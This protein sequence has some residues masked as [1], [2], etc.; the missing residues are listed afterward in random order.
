[1]WPL[2][3]IRVTSIVVVSTSTWFAEMCSANICSADWVDLNKVL[4]S[5][6]FDMYVG[7]FSKLSGVETQFYVSFSRHALFHLTQYCMSPFHVQASLLLHFL[8]TNT[9][10]HTNTQDACSGNDSL[11]VWAGWGH[12]FHV[13]SV[14]GNYSAKLWWMPPETPSPVGV[15]TVGNVKYPLPPHLFSPLPF[16]LPH[17]RD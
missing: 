8:F 13:R 3:K 17:T 14:C 4:F 2:F 1:M 9:Y 6:D 10:I 11:S 12:I 5:G 15:P 16:F 7:K